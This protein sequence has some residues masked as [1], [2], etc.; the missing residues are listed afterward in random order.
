MS[1]IAVTGHKGQIGRE[2]IKRGYEPLDCDITNL[3]QVNESIHRV[4]PDVIIHC[5]AM[6]DVEWC[7]THEKRAF[8]VN[9]NGTNNLL[10]DFT[11]TLIYL[12]T[13]H[14]FNGQKY[15]DYSEKSRPDPVNVYQVG[16]GANI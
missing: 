9:V 14:V 16:G 8:A 1:K 7:E 6:T 11:G 2:L 3:D 13:V 4:N 5:A 12:S 15:W 10:Y